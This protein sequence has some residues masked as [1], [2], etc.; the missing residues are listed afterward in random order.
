MVGIP[1]LE[2][3]NAPSGLITYPE[4]AVYCGEPELTDNQCALLN[5]VVIIE[6]LSPSTRC[7]DLSDK[8]FYRSHALRGNASKDAPAS[9]KKNNYTTL[10]RR[11]L[12]SHAGAWKRLIISARNVK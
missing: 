12:H 11:K 9:R 3:G 2:F 1:K 4:A 5:P 7:Y 8:F 10:E 6:V